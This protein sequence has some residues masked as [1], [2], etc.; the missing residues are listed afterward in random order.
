M[1][2]PARRTSL[3]FCCAIAL[4]ATLAV[5]AGPAAASNWM[6]RQLPPTA[7]SASWG[8]PLSGV[9]CPSD[10]LCVA[11]GGLNT[12]A[13]SQAPAAD[14]ARWQV[15]NPPYPVGPGKTC[16]EGEPH[17]PEPPAG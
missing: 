11:V 6:E 17:C 1:T 8:P 14:D 5:S 9:S 12:L 10:S 2:S 4:I 16:V 15:V 7:G 13:F 3:I